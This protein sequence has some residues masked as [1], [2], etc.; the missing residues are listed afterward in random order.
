MIRNM[1][2]TLKSAD[3][4]TV[5]LRIR[6]NDSKKHAMHNVFEQTAG[7]VEV[8]LKIVPAF[9]QLNCHVHASILFTVLTDLSKS[10]FTRAGE[11]LKWFDMMTRQSRNDIER[12]HWEQDH[13]ILVFNEAKVFSNLW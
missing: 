7:H 11:T 6:A 12:N 13:H 5:R 9:E 8:P 4:L 10:R 2:W 1:Q 3:S